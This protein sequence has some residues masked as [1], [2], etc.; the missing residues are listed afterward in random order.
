MDT[1]YGGAWL[2]VQ[3]RVVLQI[4]RTIF[5]RRILSV[6]SLK[7]MSSTYVTYVVYEQARTGHRDDSR[8]RAVQ[9]PSEQ[10]TNK[11]KRASTVSHR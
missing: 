4:I 6:K 2:F 1:S 10:A 7:K 5:L 3:Y 11:K 9:G 8:I